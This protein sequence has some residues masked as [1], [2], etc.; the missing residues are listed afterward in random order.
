MKYGDFT[1]RMLLNKAF[2]AG[3]REVSLDS[4]ESAQGFY[5]SVGANFVR[6]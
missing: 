6:S 1:V 3:I 5:G 4:Q 2:T